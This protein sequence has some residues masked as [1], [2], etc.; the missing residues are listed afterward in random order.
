ML[1][2]GPWLIYET[3]VLGPPWTIPFEFPLYQWTVAVLV[4]S[5]GM[6]LDPAGRSVSIAFFLLTL[7]PTER[8]LA[9]LRV[10]LPCR[11]VILS[12]LVASPFYIFW[13]GTFL[14]EST[15]LFLATSSLACDSLGEPPALGG[16]ASGCGGNQQSGGRRQNHNFLAVSNCIHDCRELPDF[17]AT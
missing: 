3:P 6:A 1:R 8:I 2:G 13:S 10:T 15:A 11:L 12:L 5:T 16:T 17:A 14:I 4:W 9:A 7:W